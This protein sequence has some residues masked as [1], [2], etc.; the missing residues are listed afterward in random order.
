MEKRN[1]RCE[2]N[3][4]RKIQENTRFT[5]KHLPTSILSRQQIYFLEESLE[6]CK[7]K[8]NSFVSKWEK[9]II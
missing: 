9:N 5:K 8:R 6:V 3:Q 7:E 4:N 1:Y 2:E